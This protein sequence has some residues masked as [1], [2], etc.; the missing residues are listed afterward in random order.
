MVQPA[1]LFALST[2]GLPTDAG[3]A[4]GAV[5]SG[6][7]RAARRRAGL[8]TISA[9]W[10]AAEARAAAAVGRAA[11]LAGTSSDAR[12]LLATMV[13]SIA[14]DDLDGA[15]YVSALVQRTVVPA[16]DT[17]RV[18]GWLRGLAPLLEGRCGPSFHEEARH[19]ASNVLEH[20][21]TTSD[22]L[23]DAW[24][25]I[26]GIALL[27]TLAE[28][29]SAG[30]CTSDAE[31]RLIQ[32]AVAT[33][34]IRRDTAREA[35]VSRLTGVD[36]ATMSNWLQYGPASVEVVGHRITAPTCAALTGLSTT[37]WRALGEPGRVPA[38]SYDVRGTPTWDEGQVLRWSQEHAGEDCARQCP[39]HQDG[40]QALVAVAGVAGGGSPAPGVG[41]LVR[42]HLRL[43]P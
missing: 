30:L 14:H 6:G 9:C 10:T 2:V 34:L 41:S 43:V 27:E 26:C 17:A 19:V 23:A 42:P 28:G 15:T 37:Q 7:R 1:T 16:G 39:A 18:A 12:V 33:T 24:I 8:P 11:A 29:R 22:V 36:R 31:V 21:H 20:P 13:A 5:L 35:C 40:T 38:A 3:Q 4:L 32:R 25:S